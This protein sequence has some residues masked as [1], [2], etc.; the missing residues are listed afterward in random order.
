MDTKVKT[1]A[2]EWSKVKYP[3][4]KTGASTWTESR[5]VWTKTDTSVWSQVWPPPGV[6]DNIVIPYYDTTDVP[7]DATLVNTFD[8]YPSPRSHNVVSGIGNTGGGETHSGYDHSGSLTSY[9]SGHGLMTGL[10]TIFMPFTQRTTAT[11]HSHSSA[12]KGEA[13]SPTFVGITPNRYICRPYKGGSY[14]GPGA[15]IPR[16]SASEG[17]TAFYGVLAAAYATTLNFH[18]TA[19]PGYKAGTSHTHNYSDIRGRYRGDYTYT[20]EVRQQDGGTQYPQHDHDNF[21]AGNSV[22]WTSV[23]AADQQPSGQKFYPLY[24]KQRIYDPMNNLQSGSILFQTDGDS[25]PSGWTRWA[26]GDTWINL[27]ST[28]IG[29]WAG[30]YGHAHY[31]GVYLT[32]STA[33]RAI[34][35]NRKGTGSLTQYGVASH[36]HSL[37]VYVDGSA[38]N[39]PAYTYFYVLVKN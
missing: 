6:P 5:R 15:L 18:S 22:T 20:D 21:T 4:I 39:I 13:T 3:H 23:S 26:T 16:S 7:W 32:I 30:S 24:T 17:D 25:T 2:T 1:G 9:S 35:S 11:S 38:N 37:R 14:I 12:E 28:G 33:F 31:S 27:D 19:T 29:D 10:N 8:S 34:T 36:T